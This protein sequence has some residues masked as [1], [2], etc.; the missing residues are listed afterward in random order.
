M[1]SK[2]YEIWLNYHE[3]RI[4]GPFLDKVRKGIINSIDPLITYKVNNQLMLIPFSHQLPYFQKTYPTY[5]TQL[6]R[7]CE[8]INKRKMET[9]KVVIIDVG[10]NLGDSVINIGIRNAFYLCIEGEKKFSSLI[11][12]NLKD[13]DYKI[14]NVFLT[15]NETDQEYESIEKHGTSHLESVSHDKENGN[16]LV[17]LD[18]LMKTKYGDIKADILKIDT[19]GFDFKVIRGGMEYIEKYHPLIYFE[20]SKG[21]LEMQGEDTLSIFP[22]VNQWGYSKAII[23]DNFGE[24]VTELNTNDTLAFR[25]LLDYSKSKEQKICYYD[26]LLITSKYSITELIENL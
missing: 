15:D 10:A 8:F 25:L 13:Y 5:D 18:T 7:I 14:E 3:S 16:K 6:R 22:I 24:L 11:K 23:F 12:E 2:I 4:V 20:W 9:E 17:K 26:I 1:Y 21:S 19:D